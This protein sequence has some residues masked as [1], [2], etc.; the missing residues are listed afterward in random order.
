M[1]WPQTSGRGETARTDAQLLADGTSGL[2]ILYE[3]HFDALFRYVAGRVGRQ[4]AEDVV[5]ET[6]V[7][8]FS[9]RAA[10]D[11]SHGSAL[12]WLIGIAT[13]LLRSQRRAERKHLA[14]EPGRIDPRG[15]PDLGLDDTL[16]RVDAAAVR[17]AVMRAVR[18]LAPSE[19]EAFMVHALAS[20]E[21]AELGVALG[22][23][24]SAAAVRLHRA[25]TKLRAALE[26]TLRPREED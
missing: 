7:I 14:T 4:A 21:G 18:R 23:S 24:S 20:L 6:F 25:R 15:A 22:V 26:P 17:G 1:A 10:F 16:S 8:A 2:R 13:N 9:R 12:P 5:A 11:P 3:R 19:R